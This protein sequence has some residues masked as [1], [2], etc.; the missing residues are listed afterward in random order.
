M[1]VT[2]MEIET[3]RPFADGKSFGE[4]GPYEQ[5]DGI[6]HFAVD[7]DH[8]ANESIADLKLA[9]RDSAGLVTFSSDFRMLRPVGPERGN[10]RILMDIPN[11]GK[12]LALRNINSAPEVAPDVPMDPLGRRG[13][14]RRPWPC[15]YAE[16]PGLA[17]GR[18]ADRESPCWSG[19]C[20]GRTA[21]V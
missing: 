5:L 20:D 6:I 16:P 21:M 11:R 12:P 18:R 1:P 2:K 14:V 3:R 4:T 17:P 15:P 7:P 9:P 19:T 8:T 10:R 13:V